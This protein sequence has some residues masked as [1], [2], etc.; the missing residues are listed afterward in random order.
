MGRKGAAA[1]HQWGGQVLFGLRLGRWGLA[2]FTLTGFAWNLIQTVGFYQVVG[3]SAAERATF[4]ASIA[5]LAARFTALVP[6]PIQ[7]E[8]V[9]GYVEFR[10]FH[11]LAIIFSVWALFAATGFARGDEECG[12]VEASLAAGA[13]RT[14][15]VASRTGSFAI[16]ILVASAASGVAFGIGLASG[17]GTVDPRRVIEVCALLVAIGLASYGIALL[18]AQ[19]ATARTAAASAGIV[20]LALFLLNSLSRSFSSLSTWR[21]LSPVRFYVLSPPLPPVGYFV[22]PGF[23]VLILVATITVAPAAAAVQR[24]HNGEALVPVPAGDP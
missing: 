8:T 5:T 9:G 24:R 2:G 17:G 3:H 1:P 4:G 11:E 16:A 12:I 15:L 21:W 14:A 18:V 19:L 13:W 10:G 6:P 20:L 23:A 7:P 22:L